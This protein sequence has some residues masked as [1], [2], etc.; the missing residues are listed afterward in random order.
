MAEGQP[1]P[2]GGEE[3]RLEKLQKW[4]YKLLSFGSG[5]AP[6]G[7]LGINKSKVWKDGQ[8]IKLSP[9]SNLRERMAETL[10]ELGATGWNCVGVTHDYTGAPGYSHDYF[11]VFKRPL[12]S[13]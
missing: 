2:E 5:E 6:Q 3:K 11:L 7:V 1:K 13:S 10:N 12:S 9:G 4:E 8:E